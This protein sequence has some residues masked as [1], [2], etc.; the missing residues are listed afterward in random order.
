MEPSTSDVIE[1]LSIE[2]LGNTQDFGDL[3]QTRKGNAACASRIRGVNAGG[4]AS[5]GTQE[6]T[7]DFVTIASTGMQLILVICTS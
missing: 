5:P 6:T 4:G 3:T 1:Y 2:T 7:I